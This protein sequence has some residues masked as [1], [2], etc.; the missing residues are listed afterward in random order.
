MTV[1]GLHSKGMI[2]IELADRDYELAVALRRIEQ[3]K[4]GINCLTTIM[5]M[6]PLQ[7]APNS[8]L[9]QNAIDY[10]ENAAKEPVSDH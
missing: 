4:D 9:L 8:I 10:A 1:E 6:T 5:G 3:L 2:A 7:Y